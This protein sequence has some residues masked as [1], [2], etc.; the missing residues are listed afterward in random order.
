MNRV[1][2]WL[3]RMRIGRALRWMPSDGTALD[4]GCSDG[5]LF[6]EGSTLI[7]SGLGVDTEEPT[8]WP[9]GPYQFRRGSFPDVLADGEIFD[10]VMMLAV[11]EHVPN[12]LLASWAA[13]VPNLLRHGGRLI[14]TIPSPMVDRI[15]DVGIRLRL[16]H[17]MD[18]EH[19]HGL[20]PALIPQKFAVG[21][22]RLIKQSR[23][24][25]GLNHLLVFER[26]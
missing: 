8:T 14:M 24:E 18:V 17:G 16:L 3:Q 6:R 1:D 2:R 21:P 12:E 26:R 13:A 11:V 4:V 22:M 23:F 15:L 20:D 25:F 10:A 5:T 19:H 7:K 9:D